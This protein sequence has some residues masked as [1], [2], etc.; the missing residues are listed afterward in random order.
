MRLYSRSF[1]ILS[2]IS[3]SFSIQNF[4]AREIN[5][6]IFY[7]LLSV[8]LFIMGIKV[9]NPENKDKYPSNFN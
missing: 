6:G 7:L 1:S 9:V 8:V 2:G 4:F 5:E 3:L